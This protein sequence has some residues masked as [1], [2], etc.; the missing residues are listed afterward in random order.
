MGR[1]LVRPARFGMIWNAALKMVGSTGQWVGRG[2]SAEQTRVGGEG[3]SNVGETSDDG[4]HD[5]TTRAV[6]EWRRGTRGSPKTGVQGRKAG[7]Q[8]KAVQGTLEKEK[9]L[10]GELTASRDPGIR[11]LKQWRKKEDKG[12]S[13]PKDRSLYKRH[14]PSSGDAPRI[15]HDLDPLDKRFSEQALTIR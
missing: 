4:R 12:S 13:E 7:R 14:R 8:G 15:T 6:D 5:Q 2:R 3:S 9:I 1:T 10:L 11:S